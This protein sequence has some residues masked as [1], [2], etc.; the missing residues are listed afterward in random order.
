MADTGC[1][2]VREPRRFVSRKGRELIQKS[3]TTSSNLRVLVRD[4]R[5]TIL[6]RKQGVFGCHWGKYQQPSAPFHWT[7]KWE[8]T[9]VATSPFPGEMQRKLRGKKKSKRGG[10]VGCSAKENPRGEPLGGGG[11]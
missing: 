5:R 11:P 2:R 7:V 10:S 9:V 1:L 6:P 4:K 3:L 8:K